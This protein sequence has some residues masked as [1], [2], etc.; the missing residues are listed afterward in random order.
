MTDDEIYDWPARFRAMMAAHNDRVL[1]RRARRD[2][3]RAARAFGLSRRQAIKLAKNTQR[4]RAEAARQAD[5]EPTGS[6]A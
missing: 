6:D 4:Q 3:F 5:A 1:K 2:A